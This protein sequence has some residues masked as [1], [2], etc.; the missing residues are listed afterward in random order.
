MKLLIHTSLGFLSEGEGRPIFRPSP[1]N[2][3]VF[4]SLSEAQLAGYGVRATGRVSHFNIFRWYTL[5]EIRDLKEEG[6]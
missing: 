4:G 3:K 5:E 6:F 1:E 2:A